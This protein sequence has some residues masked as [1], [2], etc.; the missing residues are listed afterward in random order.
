MG[1]LQDKCHTQHQT[2][3]IIQI[4]NEQKYKCQG[5]NTRIPQAASLTK[6]IKLYSI[7]NAIRKGIKHVAKICFAG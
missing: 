6:G 1:K 7:Y 4:I 3:T 2:P 5:I